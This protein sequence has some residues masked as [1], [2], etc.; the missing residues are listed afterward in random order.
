[1]EENAA[2]YVRAVS[3]SQSIRI[4]AVRDGLGRLCRG[5]YHGWA[6]Q[7]GGNHYDLYQSSAPNP[8]HRGTDTVPA[9]RHRAPQRN[10][11]PHLL[12][13]RMRLKQLLLVLRRKL[14]P[15]RRQRPRQRRLPLLP[16]LHRLRH[17]G[18]PQH[19]HVQPR[20]PRHHRP[21]RDHR[22]LPL[23]RLEAP[24]GSGLGPHRAQH[25]RNR[26]HHRRQ[27]RQLHRLRPQCLVLQQSLAPLGVGWINRND[28]SR[29]RIPR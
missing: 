5:A 1:M 15:R 16:R 17:R 6:T 10:R 13:R 28:L 25:H 22:F 19:S 11:P 9:R 27:R 7:Y 12:G 23:R 4:R 8:R 14:E 18:L 29:H 2:A 21:D 20:H 26:W 3:T 24:V